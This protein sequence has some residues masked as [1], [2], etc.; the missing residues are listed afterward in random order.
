MTGNETLSEEQWHFKS[1][2]GLFNL[3]W[4][5]LDKSERT[6]EEQEQMVHAAHASLYHW[7]VIGTPLE[8]ERGEWQ[9]SR[10]YAVLNRPEP[11][12]HHAKR[13][14]DIC[15]ANE[16][17]DFDIAFAYEAMA[18]ASAIAGQRGDCEKY[19]DLAKQAG[20]RIEDKDNRNYF[21][22][23]LATVPGCSGSRGALWSLSFTFRPLVQ[24]DAQSILTWRYE[25]PYDVYNLRSQDAESELKLLLDPDNHYYAI[26]NE[27]GSL[28]AYCCFGLDARVPGGDYQEEALDIG[29]GV[30]PDLTGKGHG[31]RYVDAA[32]SFARREFRP[33][34]LRV[35]V[36]AF[37][38]RALRVWEK[39]G[40]RQ[41][42]TFAREPDGMPFVLLSRAA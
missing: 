9:I 20:D 25:P 42:S 15:Q 34:A 26:T 1:A 13:C 3:V 35:S 32:V 41:A 17:G 2:K 5:L 22:S 36:A 6:V 38:R 14:L 23:E 12:L 29:L 28:L 18:R 16:I 39:A 21:F 24:A 27:H 40:F 31:Q 19:T 30:R 7:G 11:A 10:V 33:S 37:N 8:F 4:D